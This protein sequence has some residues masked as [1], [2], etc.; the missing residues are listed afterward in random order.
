MNQYSNKMN[1]IKTQLE[2]VNKRGLQTK[3][4]KKYKLSDREHHTLRE[5]F[6]TASKNI[7]WFG[8]LGS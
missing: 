8:I 1:E 7:I 3:V 4:R 6:F 2:D 5:Q